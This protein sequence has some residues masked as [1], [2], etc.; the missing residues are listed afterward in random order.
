MVTTH[1]PSLIFHS[2]DFSETA[3]ILKQI[4]AKLDKKQVL[5]V[6]DQVCAFQT[7]PSTKMATLAPD[8]Q[9][10]LQPQNRF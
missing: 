7:D 8:W 3:Y 4:L 6:L 1:S 2:F 10:H 5:N 9:A